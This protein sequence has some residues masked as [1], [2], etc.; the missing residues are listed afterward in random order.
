LQ[1]LRLE[2]HQDTPIL[3]Q[4]RDGIQQKVS[5]S[6]E[7]WPQFDERSR[8]ANSRDLEDRVGRAWNDG[9]HCECRPR[10][11][12]LPSPDDSHWSR[13]LDGFPCNRLGL[14]RSRRG[15]AIILEPLEY[16]RTHG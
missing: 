14:E 7:K 3:S 8:S 11:E 10:L 2:M 4:F 9:R 12:R 1:Q 5:I 16:V 15:G 13:S 6:R